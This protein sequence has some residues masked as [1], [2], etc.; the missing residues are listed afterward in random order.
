MSEFRTPLAA[1]ACALGVTLTTFGLTP[2]PAQA[3]PEPCFSAGTLDL[4]GDGHTDAVVGDPYANV[5]GQAGAGRVVVLYGDADHRVGQGPRAVLTVADLGMTPEA[6]DHFGW[7]V[8]TGNIDMDACADLVVGA[9]GADLPEP[10]A[11]AVHVVY[12]SKDG[13]NAGTTSEHLTQFD[14]GGVIEAGDHFGQSVAVGENLGQDTSVVVAGAPEEN[15]GAAADAGAVNI[16][17]FSDTIPVQPREVTQN[18]PG[19]PDV[20]E[21]GDKFGASLA[22]GVDLLRNDGSWELLAGAPGESV[23]SRASA[24]S[25]TL[26]AEIQG[27]PP[28]GT[29]QAAAYTQNSPGVGGVA[30]R[31]DRFGASLAV[32]NRN[33]FSPGTF[34]R[35]A[36]GAPGE[37]VGP[38]NAA[39]A[40]NLFTADS[41][42][43]QGLTYLT[44]DTPGVRNS[45][46]P[47]DRFG[48]SVAVMSG[49]TPRLAVGTPYENLG[50]STD[51]G[52]V[53]RFRFDHVATDS[54]LTQNSSGAAGVVHDGSRYGSPVVALEGGSERVFLVGNPFHATGTVHVVNVTGGFASRAWLPNSGGVPGGASR[55][56]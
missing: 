10:E 30:E 17:N 36:V 5:Q 53:Q 42:G 35:V 46:E 20:V 47:G 26:V 22:L 37:D 45:S 3:A 39:G 15:I 8:A 34:R 19:I 2:T 50:S 31:G 12:G 4:N 11:G 21:A 41:S 9:P 40:V 32:G 49:T 51:A 1:V 25:V 23:G 29:W 54:A 52:M 44:Q 55:F 18:T 48:A 13:L 7:S 16:V 27:F 56:G 38:D 43:L 14:A 6:G 33:V 28:T 24:G